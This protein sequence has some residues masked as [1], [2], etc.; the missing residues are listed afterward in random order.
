MSKLQAPHDAWQLLAP[1]LTDSRREKMLQVASNRTRRIKLL[2]QDV[3]NP[4]NVSACIRSAEAFGICDVDVVTLSPKFKPSTVAR[5]VNHWLNIRNFTSVQ[6][7]ADQ[8]HKDG[9]LIAA[10][11][12]CQSSVP[13]HELSVDKPI[14]ILF[15]NEHAGVANE[16]LPYIDLKFTI[17]MVGVV[18]SLN[19]SVCAAITM[20][21]LTHKAKSTLPKEEYYLDPAAKQN[22][23]N[24]WIC[25]Q[26]KTWEAECG[27]LRQ[28]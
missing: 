23:L 18:E 17:P 22:L 16:W 11:M 25:S 1:R 2:L 6:E 13:M 8:A 14:A 24:Q 20:Q 3:H 12:P 28:K 19:I 21:H 26:V 7:C 5:G 9:Y 4:H 15:G 10:G 27:R